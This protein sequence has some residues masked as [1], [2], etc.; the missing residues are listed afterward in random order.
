MG[1]KDRYKAKKEKFD[2]WLL[3]HYG[4]KVALE[5]AISFLL[6]TLSALIFAVGFDCF[7]DPGVVPL[8]EGSE[9]LQSIVAGGV[10][11]I[12]Q[13]LVM[14]F[15]V[16]YE[17]IN[18]KGSS[19]GLFSESLAYSILYFVINI[20][21]ICLAWFGIGKRFTFFT[22]VNIVETSLFMQLFNVE[23]LPVV[24]EVAA[25]VTENGGLLSR[26]LLGGVCTGLSAAIAF[27]IDASTGGVD[28]IAYYIALKKKALVGKYSVILNGV[29]LVC[30][31]LL[32]IAKDSEIAPHLGGAFYSCIYLF[33]TKIVVDS[34]NVRNKKM[35]VEIISSRKDLGEFLVETV[36][37]GATMTEGTGVYTGQERYV[38]TMVVSSYELTTLLD[39][40]KKEDE[41]AFV[42]VV[43]LTTLSGRFYTK[44]VR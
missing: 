25:F 27:K 40:I 34:I 15:E 11:G 43:P 23:S 21:V 41:S 26:G 24:G 13:T 18:G 12:S 32:S 36:P 31:T 22:L 30:F 9:S 16:I 28:V 38:F 37:H 29:T 14:F 39:A 10:S 33:M 35:R 7:M 1:I 4:L 2:R 8:G 3:D 19:D 17:A 42:S 44:P 5:Y 6:C 20:P